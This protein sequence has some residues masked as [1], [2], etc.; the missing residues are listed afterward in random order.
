MNDGKPDEKAEDERRP[1]SEPE[2]LF[3]YPVRYVDSKE[4]P[5]PVTIPLPGHAHILSS[6]HGNN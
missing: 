1:E 5:L 4:L 3:G 2:T 6:D